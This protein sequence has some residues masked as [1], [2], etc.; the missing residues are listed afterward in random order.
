MTA[1]DSEPAAGGRVK[2][3][4]SLQQ[5]LPQDTAR[6]I[7]KDIKG[8]RLKKVQ[9]AIQGDEVRVSSPSRDA[10]QEV[11]AFLRSQDYSV[12]LRFGNYRG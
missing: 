11:I 10:L 2:Q 6:A 12:E 5:G 3:E 8:L 7:V 1:G 4:I 9:T